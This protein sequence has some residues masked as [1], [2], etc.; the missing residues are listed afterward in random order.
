MSKIFQIKEYNSFYSH[1]FICI[2]ETYL[3]ST[4]LEEDKRFH[5]NRYNKLRADHPNNTKRGRVCICYKES[6]GVP[7]VKL[8]NL[9]QYVI[10]EASLQNSKVYIGVV[11]R[12]PSQDSNVLLEFY[13][14]MFYLTLMSFWVK[15]LQPTLCLP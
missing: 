7:E 4:I 12:S 2:S 10:S 3:D 6:R 11:Y 1:D 15:L 13:L 5:P 9:S 8:S 14:K